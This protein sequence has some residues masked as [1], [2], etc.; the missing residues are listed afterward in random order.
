MSTAF[1]DSIEIPVVYS[2]ETSR[3]V[4]ADRRRTVSGKM[5]QDVI[6]QKRGWNLTTRPIPLAKRNLLYNHLV[7]IDWQ[8]GDFHLDEFGIGVTIKAFLRW[9]REIRSLNQPDNRSLE[10][11]IIEQ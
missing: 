4:I 7:S 8:A 11:T 2:Q 6:A 9:G 1:F 3:D 5:R 10:L